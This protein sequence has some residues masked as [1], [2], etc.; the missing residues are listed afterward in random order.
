MGRAALDFE[1]PRPDYRSRRTFT[2]GDIRIPIVKYRIFARP[3][4]SRLFTTAIKGIDPTPTPSFYYDG[5]AIQNGR[6]DVKQS[7]S[8]IFFVVVVVV[9][10]VV[11]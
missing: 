2:S 7:T 4:K 1:L 11:L 3:N 9:V 6:S 10:I 5:R 8:L